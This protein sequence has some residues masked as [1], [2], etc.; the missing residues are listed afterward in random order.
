MTVPYLDLRA[1]YHSIK[2]EIDAAVARTLESTQY[3]LGDE[4]RAFERAFAEY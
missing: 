2:P 1:Q 4:V 3:I